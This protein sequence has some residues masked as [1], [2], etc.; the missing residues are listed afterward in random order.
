M[1]TATTE[2]LFAVLHR[3]VTRWLCAS[4]LA[5][6]TLAVSA[7]SGPPVSPDNTDMSQT[8]A[9]A[10]TEPTTAVPTAAGTGDG[11]G[12]SVTDNPTN[13][14]DFDATI[15]AKGYMPDESA[16]PTTY[17]ANC[18]TGYIPCTEWSAWSVGASTGYANV[19][20]GTTKLLISYAELPDQAWK[21]E[22]FPVLGADQSSTAS[23]L[24][25]CGNEG[26]RA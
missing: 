3:R 22:P 14:A 4:V 12:G 13:L 20:C 18:Q 2:L 21:T 26:Q 16:Q 10:M 5:G 11:Q 7:C 9:P 8:T 1:R 15:Q 17:E 23:T 6:M 25:T 19:T 24:P